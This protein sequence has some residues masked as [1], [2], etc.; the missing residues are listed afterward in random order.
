LFL[1]KRL[2][3]RQ[4]TLSKT[5]SSIYG[6]GLCRTSLLRQKFGHNF[7]FKLSSLSNHGF[8]SLSSLLNRY[9]TDF[10]LKQTELSILTTLFLYGSYKA[11][12]MR[13]GMP[14]NGQRTRSNASTSR[15]FLRTQS[16]I[17]QAYRGSLK[18]KI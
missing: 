17:S 8:A 4:L 13:Q 16:L 2:F 10:I 15:A 11:I 12:R 7:S 5:F 1:S 14:A 9:S 3:S 18:R 6:L